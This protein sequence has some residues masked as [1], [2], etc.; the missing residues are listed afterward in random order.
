MKYLES[1]LLEH[2]RGL[3]IALLLAI[4][5]LTLLSIR[6]HADE[7]AVKP[8]GAIL[9]ACKQTDAQGRIILLSIDV[10]MSDSSIQHVDKGDPNALLASMPGVPQK[11][12][13]I[14]CSHGTTS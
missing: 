14:D 8:I 9:T 6:A 11:V 3:R 10:L 7:P 13:T 5:A 4:L 1:Y 2:T 12:R